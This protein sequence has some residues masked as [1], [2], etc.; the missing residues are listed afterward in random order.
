MTTKSSRSG[1]FKA[2]QDDDIGVDHYILNY[3]LTDLSEENSFYITQVDNNH[4]ELRTNVASFPTG[5]SYSA[6]LNI[7]DL[8]WH[9]CVTNI[10]IYVEESSY[11]DFSFTL[12]KIAFFRAGSEFNFGD[13]SYQQ[14]IGFFIEDKDTT[15]VVAIA[16][17]AGQTDTLTITKEPQTATNVFGVV[18]GSINIH[19]DQA[20]VRVTA[21]ILKCFWFYIPR[22]PNGS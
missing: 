10:T 22:S 7:N 12:P 3:E 17:R 13:Q 11:F 9:L 6:T 16:E 1:C 8:V 18:R 15:D 4:V 21:R 5:N 14:E 2:A 19:F 20:W